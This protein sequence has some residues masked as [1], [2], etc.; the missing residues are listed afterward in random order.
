MPRGLDEGKPKTK[1][2]KKRK[3]AQVDEEGAGAAA[4]ENVP[5]SAANDDGPGE[6][7]EDV[8]G[9]VADAAVAA[10][11]L[12]IQPGERLSEFGARV[13]QA[14][15]ISGLTRKGKAIAGVK[16]KVT[17]HNKRLGK[18]QDQWREDEAKLREKEEEERE[19]AE[20]EWEE[21]VA[22][23]DKES[24]A[25]LITSAGGKKGKKSKKGKLI[26]EGRRGR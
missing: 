4:P 8:Q 17:K 13:N 10:L 18:M 12:R 1:A 24:R 2:G 15:P 9:A 16:E 20:E 14:L 25:L 7:S 19:V 21:K 23:M 26:G 11:A 3:L 5:T 22:G 6:Q